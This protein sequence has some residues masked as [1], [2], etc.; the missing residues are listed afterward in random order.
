MFGEVVACYQLSGGSCPLLPRSI[1]V[2][3]FVFSSPGLTLGLGI[4]PTAVHLVAS[5]HMAA[6]PGRAAVSLKTTAGFHFVGSQMNVSQRT[7]E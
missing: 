5:H 7:L 1:K 3:F 4:S 6:R 2:C